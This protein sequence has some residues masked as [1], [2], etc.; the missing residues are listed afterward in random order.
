[1]GEAR[2]ARGGGAGV[3]DGVAAVERKGMA[4]GWGRG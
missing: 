4:G 1:M 2:E 3:R